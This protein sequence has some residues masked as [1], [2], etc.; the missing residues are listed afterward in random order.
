MKLAI[1][2]IL[3]LS[4]SAVFAFSLNDL[5]NFE[6]GSFI[7][8]KS[9]DNRNPSVTLSRPVDT[10]VVNNPVVFKWRYF[11][12]E[13]DK[14][15][16]FIL[17]IDDDHRFFSPKNYKGV[18]IEFKQTLDEGTYYWRIKVVN[19]YGESFSNVWKFYVDPQMKVC[20]DGTPYFECSL[21][22]PFYCSGL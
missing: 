20:D 15:D 10:Q 19:K 5:F 3:L 7:T 11:D 18:G 1:I 14:M 17:Q 8:G 6:L 13:D 9:V 4:C 12:A 22:K 2:L 16:F 21:E